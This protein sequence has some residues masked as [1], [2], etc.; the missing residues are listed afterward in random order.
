MKI[1]AVI[2]AAGSSRR[3]GEDK[4]WL[5]L[6]GKPVIAHCLRA[7]ERCVEITEITVVARAEAHQQFEILR[8]REGITKLANIIPG[9]AERQ[10]SVWLGLSA[11]TASCDLALIHDGARPMVTGDIVRRVACAAME[12]GAAVCGAP[13]TDTIKEIDDNQ[14]VIRTPPR[15]TLMAVQTPQ[16]FHRSLIIECYRRW[17]EIGRLATDDTAVAEHFGHRVKVVPCPEPNLKVTRP[18][19]IEIIET[20]SKQ[21]STASIDAGQTP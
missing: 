7:F 9:G 17:M 4:L 1:A 19:D 10:D 12:F 6:L 20:L 11:T 5:P 2:V 15:Q 14:W 16:I 21:R 8:G 3:M 13:V 18:G